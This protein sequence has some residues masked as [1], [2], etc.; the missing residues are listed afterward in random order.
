MATEGS[1]R[2]LLGLPGNIEMPYA[3]FMREERNFAAVLY[4]LLLSERAALTCFIDLIAQQVEPAAQQSQ[5][6][7]ILRGHVAAGKPAGLYFEYAHA[8]DLWHRASRRFAPATRETPAEHQ[9]RVNH[10]YLKA[11]VSLLSERSKRC[12]ESELAEAWP[13]IE[14]LPEAHPRRKELAHV[15]DA[16]RNRAM[17]LAQALTDFKGDFVEGFNRLFD[18][19]P[20]ASRTWIQ[21]PS[22]WSRALLEDAAVSEALWESAC[23]LKW[24]FNAKADLVIECEDVA[25]CIEIKV[26]SAVGAYRL[27]R[28]DR[29][30]YM[31]DQLKVQQYILGDLLGYDTVF[32]LLSRQS[33]K[34]VELPD[35]GSA[36]DPVTI[37]WADVFDSLVTSSATL[38]PRANNEFIGHVVTCMAGS[39]H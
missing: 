31:G 35:D 17:P 24:A 30:P 32:A 1:L 9:L 36:N 8:R 20:R 39:K 18:A 15:G 2:H 13:R 22:R 16:L 37:L 4:H 26:H 33:P 27:Q 25:L 12:A 34:N 29:E 3:S 19:S 5:C 10:L 21:M 14:N 38:E 23:M 28:K 7:G 11:I 6:L